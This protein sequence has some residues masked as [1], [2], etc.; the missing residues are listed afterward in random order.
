MPFKL[1]VD[2]C[3]Q[4]RGVLIYEQYCAGVAARF[5]LLDALQQREG[6]VFPSDVS[7]WTLSDN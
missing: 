3:S 7:H 2:I 6:P 4:E 5:A 1:F